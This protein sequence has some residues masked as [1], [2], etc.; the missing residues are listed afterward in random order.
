MEEKTDQYSRHGKNIGNDLIHK[1]DARNGDE[2]REKIDIEEETQTKSK[3]TEEIDENT[4]GDEFDYE[5]LDG[6]RLLAVRAFP[7][8]SDVT[9]KRD[10]LIPCNWLFTVRTEGIRFNDADAFRHSVHE[11]IQ[12]TSYRSAK[13][14]G[15]NM[16]GEIHF[17]VSSSCNPK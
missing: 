6:N 4:S 1:V 12:K 15:E 9:Y 14:E 10:I 11:N 16:E 13:Q 5:I 2:N 17:F 7:S 8:Q 3:L